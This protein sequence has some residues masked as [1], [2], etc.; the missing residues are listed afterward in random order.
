[1]RCSLLAALM[2]VAASI[3]G[4]CASMPGREPLQVSVA[5]IEP[6]P[7]GD[8]ELRMLVNLRVQN[9][10]D[11]TLEYNGVYVKLEVQGQTFATG[12]SNE[13]GSVPRFGETV[14][15][16]PVTASMLRMAVQALRMLGGSPVDKIHYKLDGK[17]EGPVFGS[18]SFRA[19]G[20]FALP[21]AMSP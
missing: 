5:D 16:V 17:L 12:V 8:L 10:N 14:I 20:E 18:T 6:L 9:P 19:E 1:M 21:D 4:A 3:L 15:R 7:G 13:H 2:M 11:A